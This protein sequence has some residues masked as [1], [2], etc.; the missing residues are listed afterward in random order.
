MNHFSP[1]YLSEM[2]NR[3]AIVWWKRETVM[4][5]I[6]DEEGKPAIKEFPNVITGF[7]K[8]SF[9]GFQ[10]DDS[11]SFPPNNRSPICHFRK[12]FRAKMIHRP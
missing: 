6:K 2:T 7:E 11:F 9:Q 12:V 10:T 8:N 4:R 5:N 3:G 1:E